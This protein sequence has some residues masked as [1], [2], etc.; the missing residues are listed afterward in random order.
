MSGPRSVVKVGGSLFDMPDLGERLR[1]WLATQDTKKILLVPGGGPTADVIHDLDRCHALGEEKSHWLALRSLALN[2]YVLAALLPLGEVVADLA[3]CESCWAAGRLPILDAHAFALADEGRPGCLPHIWDV[4]SD[5]IAARVAAVVGA[6]SL[7]L[8]KSVTIPQD[9]GWADAGR[10]GWVDS[11][12]AEV[13]R[14]A[15]G[16]RVSAVNLREWTASGGC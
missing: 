3:A 14:Q 13:L 7:V 15:P 10:R 8:L 9:M 2:A 16:L 12:F 5:S 4:T 1:R 11:R 6:S